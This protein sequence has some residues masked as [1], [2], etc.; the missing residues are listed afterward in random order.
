[1]QR[2]L[3]LWPEAERPPKELNFWEQLDP[4][5]QAMIIAILS[6]LIRKAV[7]PITQEDNHER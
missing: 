1:V 3:A 6:R 4:E 2:Q 7:S 5:M